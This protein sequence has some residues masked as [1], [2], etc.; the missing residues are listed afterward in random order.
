MSITVLSEQ[1]VALSGMPLVA[2]D[3]T[4]GKWIMREPKDVVKLKLD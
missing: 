1:S 3:F 2:P 4:R